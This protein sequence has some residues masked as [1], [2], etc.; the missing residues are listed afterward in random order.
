MTVDSIPID[1][2]AVLLGVLFL[3]AG[4][5]YSTLHAC[6]AEMSR[7]TI[8]EL[9]ARR[10]VGVRT[11]INRVLADVDG[12]ARASALTRIVCHLAVAVCAVWV[13][14]S[15][16]GVTSPDLLDGFLGVISS[17]VLLWL[18][19]ATVAESIA[20]HVPERFLITFSPLLR[21]TYLLQLPMAPLARGVDA[22]VRTISG[23]E[24]VSKQVE[25]ADEILDAVEEGQREG[26]IDQGERKMIESVVG[27]KHLTVEQIM[28]PRNEIE[29]LELTANL[30]AITAFVRKARHSR[31]PVYKAGGSLDDVVG[32]FYVKDLLRWLSGDM[33][34]GG[35][36]ISTS[37]S[38]SPSQSRGVSGFDLKHLL[39][40][41]FFVPES[42]TVRE[43][44][45]EL[46]EKKV[47]AAIVADEYGGVAGIVTIEDIVEE[48]F[49]D[50]QDE[51]E[52]AED[53]PPRID[54]R[55]EDAQA[56]IDARAYIDDVNE[57][58]SPLGVVVP[59]DD[60]YDTLG[61]FVLSHIGRMAEV[62]ESFT[63]GRAMYTVLEATPARVLKVRVQVREVDENVEVRPSA[64]EKAEAGL[65]RGK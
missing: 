29:A 19:S 1:A 34:V 39:R 17:A 14:A 6:L 52:K 62:N 55:V 41:A 65:E 40:P 25:L 9:A 60:E 56:D 36:A 7:S 16:R 11:R 27:F 12:H 30:G 15:V 57:A 59:E 43:L 28:T 4:S 54:V 26:A 63:H 53:D 24:K 44:L 3:A 48:V 58:L 45:D 42:K 10:S 37:T 33:S 21:A 18:L 50:I 20:A 32:F 2:K 47:H 23:G 38:T 61:G 35:H 46:V 13:W 22:L 8:E 64:S 49:G 31:I 51:Y 5:C